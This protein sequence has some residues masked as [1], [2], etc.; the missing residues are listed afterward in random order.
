MSVILDLAFVS[1]L[2]ELIEVTV[3]QLLKVLEIGT[4]NTPVCFW[5]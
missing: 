1:A 5:R 2:L 4:G 3:T